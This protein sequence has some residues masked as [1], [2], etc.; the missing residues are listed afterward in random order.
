MGVPSD[1]ASDVLAEAQQSASHPQ[2]TGVDATDIPFVTVD[3]PGST[4]LDQAVHLTPDGDGFVVRYAIADVGSFVRPGGALDAETHRRGETLYF[5][6]ARVPL[7]P[8][9]LSEGAASLLPGQIRPA[10]LWTMTLGADGAVRAVD[11]VRAKV[12]SIAQLDY[13]G[14]QAALEAGRLPGPIAALPAVG[15]ARLAL[16]RARHSINLDLPEQVVAPGGPLGW[17]LSL[18]ADLD[19]ERYNAEISLLTGMCAARIMIDGGYGILRTVPPPE[20]GAVADLRRAA[21]ALG[22]DWPDGAA[23]GDVLA[24]V[25]RTDPHQAAVIEHAVSLLRGAAYTVFDGPPP[26]QPLHSGIG[27]AY[28]HVTA[29]LRRL[30]DRYAAEICLHLHAGTPVPAWVRSAL[31]TLPAEMAG[32]DRRA[33]EID[34]AVVDATEAFVLRDQVGSVFEAVV[35]A[36][37]GKAGT[38]VLDD[39][40]V[41]ARCVGANLPVGERVRVRLTSADVTARTVRFERVDGSHP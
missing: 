21:A 35:I 4:D 12:R 19:V 7:H 16:A 3:P 37:D 28:T 25:D 15:Q 31:P 23:P 33:H 38:V 27:A 17:T 14:V 11:V 34:R 32:A 36:A 22:V 30:V 24:T 18:R 26:A 10:V 13:P 20:E 41:R 29:P 5:P 9:L 39:L 6:D 8:P 1:F 2:L 40:A